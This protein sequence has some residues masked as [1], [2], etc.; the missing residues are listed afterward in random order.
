MKRYWVI[1]PFHSERRKIFEKVWEYDLKNGTVAIGWEKLGDT[2]GMIKSELKSKYKEVYGNIRFFNTFWRY[3]HDVS[4]GDI[5]IARQGMK[6]IIG[7]GT[8][9]RKAY[10]DEDKGRKRHADM[11]EVFNSNF[12]DVKW[13]E[14]K[15]DF[16]KIVFSR[17]TTY[18]ITEA[19]CNSLIKAE[20][21][22]E[23]KETVAEIESEIIEKII[24]N[25]KKWG[26]RGVDE[27]N[28]KS[29]FIE[30][31]IN[32]LGRNVRDLD[33]VEREARVFLE[34]VELIFL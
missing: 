8:V 26:R 23:E 13:E 6:K 7:I 18:E 28:T 3:W 22:E 29:I 11:T 14:K 32:S 34:V 33:V 9:E 24:K 25:Y 10:Y 4:P 1:A 20:I 16:D 5:I 27:Y 2:T 21:S 30:P 31:L 17:I 19:K 15:I 12:I